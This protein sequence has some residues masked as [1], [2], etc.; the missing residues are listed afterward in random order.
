MILCCGEALIDLLP[1]GQGGFRPHAGGAVCNTAIALGRLGL[2]SGLFWGLSRDA[3]GDLLRAA[4]DQ[5]GVD[6]RLSVT[7]DRP[8]TLALVTLDHGQAR[9]AFYDEGSAGRML[10]AADLPDPGRAALFLG[11]IALAAEPCGSAIE[12]LLLRE[13]GRRAI[14]IDPNIRPRFIRDEA[15]FRARLDRI[16]PRA[17]IVKLS[18]EDLD[19]LTP[20]PPALIAG[21]LAEGVRLVCVTRGAAGVTAHLPGGATLHQPAR[22]VERVIDT[23]GAGDTFNA[24]LLAGLLL[25]GALADGQ[26]HELPRAGLEMALRLGTA[27]A[28]VTVTRAGAD[29]PRRADLDP[30]L[31]A[32]GA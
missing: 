3:M 19:W 24:G 8:S 26:L 15:A 29:S 28:A 23:V 30:A 32:T 7:S 20:D 2:P 25:S 1:D 18:E 10:T 16:L 6:H 31:F 11:G 22:Q 12:A 14:M 27:A 21:L 5:S 13:S 9:Y 17:T 4:L